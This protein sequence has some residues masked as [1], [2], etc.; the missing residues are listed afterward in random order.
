MLPDKTQNAFVYLLG[1]NFDFDKTVHSKNAVVSTNTVNPNYA[2]IQTVY[3]LVLR[4][5][6]TEESRVFKEPTIVADIL[7]INPNRDTVSSLHKLETTN[8]GECRIEYQLDLEKKQG[9]GVFNG[10][11]IR[12][13]I[14]ECSSHNPYADTPTKSSVLSLT[15]QDALF[16]DVHVARLPQNQSVTLQIPVEPLDAEKIVQN[17]FELDGNDLVY[18]DLK[19]AL[20]GIY[21]GGQNT[22]L[23]VVVSVA[24]HLAADDGGL[25]N[26]H[27]SYL[28]EPSKQNLSLT[29]DSTYGLNEDRKISFHVNGR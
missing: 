27:R 13:E 1:D 15:F 7:K 8:V 25:L 5:L 3:S 21:D 28:M 18:A 20:S 17:H 2:A 10:D 12:N 19:T 22:D 14:R 16:R 6:L 23:H 26:F 9:G 4:N 11:E 29:V 24:S